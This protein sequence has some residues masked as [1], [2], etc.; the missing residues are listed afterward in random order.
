MSKNEMTRVKYADVK[1]LHEKGWSWPDVAM[2]LIGENSQNAAQAVA[3]V[4]KIK[5][6]STLRR[7]KPNGVS[8]KNGHDLSALN[9]AL[10]A[11]ADA[12]ASVRAKVDAL[13]PELRRRGVSRLVIDVE[14]GEAR[15]FTWSELFHVKANP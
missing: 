12:A 14:T 7:P 13:I 11:S 8:R 3:R 6:D 15:A 1:R 9:G 2:E 5:R 10:K 4:L